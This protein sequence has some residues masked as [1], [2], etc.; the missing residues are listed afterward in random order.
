MAAAILRALRTP[1]TMEGVCEYLRVPIYRVRSTV[2]E[3]FEAG[4]V[5][6]D[7]GVYGLTDGGRGR[8]EQDA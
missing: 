1:R 5:V 2:R 3:L 7:D 6:E 8:L 4:L